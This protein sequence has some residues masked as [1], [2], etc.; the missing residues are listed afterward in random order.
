M[1]V[2]TFVQKSQMIISIQT[3]VFSIG[4]FQTVYRKSLADLIHYPSHNDRILPVD[5]M[6]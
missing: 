6:W 2:E 4:V 5:L 1:L 3:V